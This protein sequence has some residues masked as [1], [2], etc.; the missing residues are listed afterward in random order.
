MDKIT[1]CIPTIGRRDSLPVV[2]NSLAFQTHR[3]D[4]LILLDESPSPITDDRMVSQSLDVIADLGIRVKV[5]RSRVKTGIG[6]ARLLFAEEAKTPLLLMVDDDVALLP[7]CLEH[8]VT[9][10]E[11]YPWCIPV[12][13]LVI[14]D[15]RS[16]AYTD[17]RVKFE[18]PIV[19]Q[20]V[21]KYPWF[22]AYFRYS[23]HFILDLE[24]SG[25]QA[26]LLR[27]DCLIKRCQNLREWGRLQRED[28]Y[29]TKRMGT[30]V[31]TSA[32]ESLHY[33]HPSQ[34]DREHWDSMLFY[35]AYTAVMEDP[36][37]F[38]QVM[39]KK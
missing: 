10:L 13:F 24:V 33:M 21:T 26:I 15:F 11:D 30:G 3:V 25:T 31:F 1:A 39:A 6:P 18:D 8:M 4:E 29:M 38:F 27:K 20:W 34:E 5:I 12:N 7:D 37:G 28:T 22:V 9:A 17:K 36:E 2:L 23:E 35:R 32:G 14:R 19:Q 16:D